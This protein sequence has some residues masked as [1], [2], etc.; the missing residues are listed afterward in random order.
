MPP[1]CR[2]A[3][4]RERLVGALQDALRADVDPAAGRHL[5]VHREAR[6]PRDRGT[7]PRSP[8]P[9]RASRWRSAR[10]APGMRAEHR[11]R[12]ARLH[13]QRLVVLEPAQRA[14]RWRRSLP[15]ARRLAGAAVD[16]EISGRSATSGSR[17][18]IS[19]RSA[20][21]CSQP[22]QESVGA[23]RRADMAAEGAHRECVDRPCARSREPPGAEG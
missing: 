19:I 13:E 21:S 7:R 6:D 8:T 14:R 9:A 16:D 2:R 20:A 11:H 22:L 12:L 3:E 4:R 5:A 1:K 10:A 18:F 15:V 17:L 23:A